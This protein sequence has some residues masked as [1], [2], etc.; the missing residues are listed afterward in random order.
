ARPSVHSL[1]LSFICVSGGGGTGLAGAA[2]FLARASPPPSSTSAASKH[3]HRLVV[4][5]VV[6]HLDSGFVGL[7]VVFHF[8]ARRSRSMR[9]DASIDPDSMARWYQARAA[10]GSGAS[11]RAPRSDTA[12]GS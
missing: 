1:I 7:A 2:F 5:I 3:P 8:G 9:R 12:V 6:A 11:P 4:S 10:L